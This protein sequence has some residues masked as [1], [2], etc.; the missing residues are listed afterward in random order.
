MREIVARGKTLVVN[1]RVWA[2]FASLTNAKR[3]AEFLKQLVKRQPAERAKEIRKFIAEAFDE[4]EISRRRREFE[5]ETRRLRWLCNGLV[6]FLFALAPAAI[7]RLGLQLS[8]LPLV[9]GLFSLSTWAA[10]IFHR[11]HRQWFPEEKDERFSHTL[12]VALAPASGARAL[13]HL[14]RPLLESFHP[15]AV[16]KVFL[17]EEGFR[18]F[19]RR[20]LLDLRHPAL[21][22]SPTN[23]PGA[24][25]AEDFM[26]NELRQAAEG[27]LK[28]HSIEPEQ[29][30]KPPMPTEES[31]RAYCPRCDAQ[32][33]ALDATCADCGGLAVVA[34]GT[35]GRG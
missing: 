7:W 6:L 15:L 30:C 19:A 9:I 34:F 10:V 14:S 11:R 4:R 8:W 17:A 22:L 13:D 26:R 35:V 18:A 29:V 27:F 23:D 24:V 25:G 28:R 21:P 31:C 33:T 32:F 3:Y 5:S 16:A 20:V 12:I 2:R 1:G